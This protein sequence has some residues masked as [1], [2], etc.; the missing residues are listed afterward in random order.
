[1][2]GALLELENQ[3][4]LATDAALMVRVAS[5]DSD[6]YDLLVDHHLNGM[7]G[8]AHRI[9]GDQGEAEDVVQESFVKLW[10]KA[11]SWQP[12]AMIRTWLFRVVYNACVDRLRH[13]REI[14]LEKMP[15]LIDE[16]DNPLDL[17][18]KKS[19]AL[20]V[21]QALATLPER[22][23]VAITLLHHLGFSQIDGAS[24]MGVSVEAF[25]SLSAR[26]RR[27]LRKKLAVEKKDW[28]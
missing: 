2:S 8:L 11:S 19:M 27:A 15:E 4:A 26:G 3:K 17:L 18:L 24:I 7:V 9:L 6:A 23:R 22:Q 14:A 1:M 20:R 13:R 12:N 10:Q 21:R 25:E 28:I 5:R 16:A